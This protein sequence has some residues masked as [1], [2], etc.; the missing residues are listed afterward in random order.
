MTTALDTVETE[1]R[2]DSRL[3]PTTDSNNLSQ[4]VAVRD[5]IRDG[6]TVGEAGKALGISR[7]TAFE[8]L[9]LIQEDVDR[10]V[11]NLLAAKGLDFAENW[12]TASQ[13]ASEK[14]DHRPAKDALL[15]IR[16]IEPVNDGT[17]GTNIAIVIGTP[18]QLIRLQPPQVVVDV[19]SE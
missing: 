12:I 1:D 16:A 10:G 3:L 9:K 15:H 8:R 6:F 13:K 2:P 4:A 5:L 7:S 14:G 11:A 19:S 17:Q 18:D